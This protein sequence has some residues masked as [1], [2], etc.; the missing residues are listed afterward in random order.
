MVSKSFGVTSSLP[1][2]PFSRL[3][4]NSTRR[5]LY[6]SSRR[7][8]RFPFSSPSTDFI[9]SILSYFSNSR[10]FTRTQRRTNGVGSTETSSRISYAEYRYFYRTNS[11][12]FYY[13]YS[14]RQNRSSL[15]TLSTSRFHFLVENTISTLRPDE[16]F[17]DCTRKVGGVFEFGGTRVDGG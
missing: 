1:F 16:T 13:S 12:D 14:E 11:F 6:R 8:P 5:S 10:N 2:P 3:E 7:F 15:F 9:R 17:L 4:S